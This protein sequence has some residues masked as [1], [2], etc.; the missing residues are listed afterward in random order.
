MSGVDI[1]SFGG[2]LACSLQAMG[3]VRLAGAV[4][5]VANTFVFLMP[6]FA[7]RLKRSE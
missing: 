7:K 6:V 3:Y 4:M 2:L 1:L 5:L